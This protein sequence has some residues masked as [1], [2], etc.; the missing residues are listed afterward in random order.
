[1]YNIMSFAIHVTQRASILESLSSMALPQLE[2]ALLQPS[3]SIGTSKKSKKQILREISQQKQLRTSSSSEKC[4]KSFDPAQDADVGD[5]NLVGTSWRK[6]KR[7]RRK[8]KVEKMILDPKPSTPLEANEGE[9]N[10]EQ[11]EEK[12]DHSSEG[13]TC[14]VHAHYMPLIDTCTCILCN[15]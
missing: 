1:M 8:L 5:A 13:N 7:K 4:V 6:R 15:I 14:M 12:S 2:M 10:D 9:S 11:L 3:T